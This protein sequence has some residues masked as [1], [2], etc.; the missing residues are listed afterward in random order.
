[1]IYKVTEFHLE[2]IHTHLCVFI[3]YVHLK[4]QK[5]VQIGFLYLKLICKCTFLYLESE[6]VTPNRQK[7]EDLGNKQDDNIRPLE[8]KA[9]NFLINEYLLSNNYKLTS[10]T[11]AEENEDQVMFSSNS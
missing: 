1:M 6:I 8:K 5:I 2:H 10:V 11:F 9:L 7:K 4:R 3:F